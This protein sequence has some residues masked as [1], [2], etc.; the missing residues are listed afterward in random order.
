MFREI[1]GYRPF[2]EIIRVTRRKLTIAIVIAARSSSD[3]LAALPSPRPRNQPA[4]ILFGILVIRRDDDMHAD[5]RPRP[6]PVFSS[7]ANTS[8]RGE[9]GRGLLSPPPPPLP[10]SRNVLSEEDSPGTKK[11]TALSIGTSCYFR[12][13]VVV[14]HRGWRK[15]SGRRGRGRV[16]WGG[17]AALRRGFLAADRR[18]CSD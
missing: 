4:R 3:R 9:K 8:R 10:P 2:H 11:V 18:C 12:Q 6:R 1:S 13:R 14:L 15:T 7:R 16:G 17:P 5:K